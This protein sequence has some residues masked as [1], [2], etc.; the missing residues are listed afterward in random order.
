MFES[1]QLV[2]K[3]VFEY[4][5]F[6]IINKIIPLAGAN[7]LL[8]NK[9]TDIH[10]EDLGAAGSAA[11]GA[12]LGVYKY[13]QFRAAE[14]RKPEAN[15]SFANG[16]ENKKEWLLGKLLAVNQNWARRLA[17][18][19]ANQMTPTKFVEDVREHISK[20]VEIAAHNK[21]WAIAQKMGSYLSVA[22]G[23][24]EPP[25]FLEL[26][27]KGN[28]QSSQPICL[29]GKGITFDSGGISLKPPSKMVCI[30]FNKIYHADLN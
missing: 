11:E 10:V 6:E 23:T 1:L 29:V 26:T 27:Y 30:Q 15:I 24:S 12:Y 4:L 19:A 13:Q 18:T 9:V 28:I 8:A 5:I 2:K 25:I 20:K 17:E 21:D 7:A 16:A 22:A 14:K 3:I